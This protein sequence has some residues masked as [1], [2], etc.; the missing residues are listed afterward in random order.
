[1]NQTRSV[2]AGELHAALAGAAVGVIGFLL[3]QI[4]DRF[5]APIF[6][7]CIC[8]AG[9]IFWSAYT[10]HSLTRGMQPHWSQRLG[11]L[12]LFCLCA[13]GL[14]DVISNR[15]AFIATAGAL[16]IGWVAA[17]DRLADRNG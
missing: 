17:E 13:S 3:L 11:L 9:V 10:R 2:Q 16:L 7:A 4:P 12:V 1:P 8:T 15:Y 6:D 5:E 14:R